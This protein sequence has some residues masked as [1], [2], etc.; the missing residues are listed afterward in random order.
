M[1]APRPGSSTVTAPPRAA[2]LDRGPGARP[3]DT[4]FA[5]AVELFVGRTRHTCSGSPHTE[6]AYRTD[7]R[8][9]AAFLTA[10]GLAFDAVTRRDAEL[11]LVRLSAEHSARTVRRRV[12][13]VRSFYRFLRTVEAVAHSPFDAAL[14]LPA[15]DRKSETH[16]VL[17][18]DELAH[19]LAHVGD[20]IQR[21]GVPHAAREVQAEGAAFL[22][23]AALG[24]DTASVSL[25]YLAAHVTEEHTAEAHLSEI[26]RIGWRLV[27]LVEEHRHG[28]DPAPPALS[29]V[30]SDPP[31][32][33]NHPARLAA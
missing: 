4:T 16:K 7:L 29:L 27:A 3:A 5:E 28:P 25:P 22:A 33:R 15:I 24:L 6:A 8:H 13:C 31:S 21:P 32:E 17:T 26:D 19:A 18:D 20:D 9:Y 10:R 23:C 30:R 1:T 14:D 2:G 12:S 11:Y